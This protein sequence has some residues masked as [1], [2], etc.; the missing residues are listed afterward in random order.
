MERRRRGGGREK[1]RTCTHRWRW[2]R[3]GTARRNGR[4]C[5][6]EARA[7]QTYS[8]A[9]S[10]S[11][12]GGGID[13][14]RGNRAAAVRWENGGRRCRGEF[15][16]VVYSRAFAEMPRA[17]ADASHL[18][19]RIV[20]NA[21]RPKNFAASPRIARLLEGRFRLRAL[22]IGGFF[23]ACALERACWRCSN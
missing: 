12:A 6:E 22:Y 13:R 23:S 11:G 16:A 21:T 17:A 3:V 7:R 5:R 18:A 10:Y 4:N 2:R 9:A 19:P 1:R 8:A 14:R 20:Q 15:S